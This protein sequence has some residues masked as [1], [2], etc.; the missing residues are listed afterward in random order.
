[1]D[2]DLTLAQS[3]EGLRGSVV[4]GKVDPDLNP[5]SARSQ[6]SDHKQGA[7]HPGPPFSPLGSGTND[8]FH[9]RLSGVE[10]G[11]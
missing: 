6:L 5:C 7:S 8:S 11:A 10:E 2:R 4:K 1:M 9:S 3:F